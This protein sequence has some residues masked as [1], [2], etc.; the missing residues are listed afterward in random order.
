VAPGEHVAVDLPM[1]SIYA[2]TDV[3]M[4]VHVVRGRRPGPCL[5]LCA[6][7][8]GDELNGVE[9][10]RRVLQHRGLQS[11]RGTLI[12][13][14]VVNVYGFLAG[15]RYLPDGRDLNRSFPGSPRGSLAS[16]MAHSFM[17]EI[18]VKATHA[19]DLHTGSGHRNNLPQIRAD[20][21]EPENLRLAR[22]FGVPVVLNSKLRDGSLRDA[23]DE[24]GVP[25]LL[26]EAGE[27]LRFDELA[28]R[29]G[30]RGVLNVMRALQML[31]RTRRKHDLPEPVLA[32][33]SSW[34]RAPDSGVLRSLLAL[35]ATVRKGER[36]GLLADPDGSNET[37]V[38]ASRSGVL[39]GR[40]FLPLV[41]E[42]DAL[43]HIAHTDGSDAAAVE[44]Y[45]EHYAGAVATGAD[46]LS[47]GG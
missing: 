20:L 47:G 21:S 25:M 12:A 24:R 1:A 4:T 42:G 36:L 33:S 11:I 27:A 32:Q 41:H 31:P 26:Y 15:T 19:I 17:E 29:A 16:R 7:I 23:A 43:F 22:A 8:H 44:S 35:G 2:H 14:P 46:A 18:V 40:S 13:I 10:I 30:A 34:E 28:I 38:L 3:R 9:V 37:P 45:R 5:L 39:I 6:A